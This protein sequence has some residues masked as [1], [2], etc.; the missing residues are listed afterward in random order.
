[1]KKFSYSLVPLASLFAATNVWAVDTTKTY[2]SGV[3]VLLFMGVCALIVVVQLLP[4]LTMLYGWIKGL[5]SSQ[6][7]EAKSYH[8]KS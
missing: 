3:L 8:R 7:V 6:N 2:T 1:M 5:T 4:A